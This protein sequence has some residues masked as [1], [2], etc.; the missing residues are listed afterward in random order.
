[1]LFTMSEQVIL[2]GVLCSERKL[3]GEWST[4]MMELYVKTESDLV[5]FETRVFNLN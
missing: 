2:D 3:R 5:H 1:M 4:Y